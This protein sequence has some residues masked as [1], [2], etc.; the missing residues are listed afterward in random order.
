MIHYQR[1]DEI[2][3]LLHA[4]EDDVDDHSSA[5]V[6]VNRIVERLKLENELKKLKKEQEEYRDGYDAGREFHMGGVMRD[7][8]RGRWGAFRRGFDAA[9]DD[10]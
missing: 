3:D 8:W 6:T 7:E 5:E 4:M 2:A 1:I 9:G 10:S